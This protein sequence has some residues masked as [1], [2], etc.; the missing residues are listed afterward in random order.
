MAVQSGGSASWRALLQRG[1]D[2]A[3]ELSDLVARKISAVTDPRARMLRQRDS[4]PDS[5]CQ[6]EFGR[7]GCHR[8]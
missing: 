5:G 6:Q 8:G 7:H 1:L 4:G 3:D 2:T